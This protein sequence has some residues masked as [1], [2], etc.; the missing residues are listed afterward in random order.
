M[1]AHSVCAKCGAKIEIVVRQAWQVKILDN[2]AEAECHEC[3][4][5]SSW[6]KVKA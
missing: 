2:A 3:Q 5:L 4:P 6:K 1:K